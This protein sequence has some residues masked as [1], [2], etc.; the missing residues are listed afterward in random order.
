MSVTHTHRRWND[1][2]GPRSPERWLLR[3]GAGAGAVMV[4]LALAALIFTAGDRY[5]I[6]PYVRNRA[7]PLV[8]TYKKEDS[9]R[10]KQNDKEHLETNNRIRQQFT[11][12]ITYQKSAMTE[13]EILKANDLLVNDTTISPELKH[14]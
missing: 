10:W 11:V 9:V 8:D 4:I 7:L 5:G 2:K 13:K 1:S 6:A 12:L 14:P 3:F